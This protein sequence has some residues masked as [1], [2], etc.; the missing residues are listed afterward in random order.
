MTSSQHA[1]EVRPRKDK[2][3]ADLISDALPYLR[4]YSLANTKV[5]FPAGLHVET[6]TI[7]GA[8]I[9]ICYARA[10]YFAVR[11]VLSGAVYDGLHP[12][13]VRSSA[14]TIQLMSKNGYAISPCR[15]SSDC[16]R[17]VGVSAWDL[18]AALKARP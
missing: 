4:D 9:A 2:R 11:L 8:E 3:A 10:L 13:G 14:R 1:Y 16:R 7:S 6:R 18:D 12:G 15:I 5:A 17:T